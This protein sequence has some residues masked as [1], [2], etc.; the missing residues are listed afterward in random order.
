[1]KWIAL[2][3]MCAA[4]TLAWSEGPGSRLRT[5]PQ[6]PPPPSA[7]TPSSLSQEEARCINLQDPR[8]ERCLRELRAAPP[9]RPPSGPE[10][11][12]MGSGAGS[13]AGSGTTG[14]ASFGGSAP[15]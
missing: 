13:A 3:A 2:A 6:V 7:A 15:R 8:K 11:T 1:M 12:G 5:S 4:A 9:G 10:S 14:G